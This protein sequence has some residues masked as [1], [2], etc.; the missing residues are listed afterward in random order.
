MVKYL[1]ATI[2]ALLIVSLIVWFGTEYFIINTIDNLFT[3]MEIK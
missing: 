1:I 3:Q 2:L